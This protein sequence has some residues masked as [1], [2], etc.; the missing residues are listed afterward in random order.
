MMHV[1]VPHRKVRESKKRMCRNRS[2]AIVRSLHFNGEKVGAMFVMLWNDG[3]SC[4]GCG[5]LRHN[6]FG[7]DG[8]SA[9]PHTASAFQRDFLVNKPDIS[10]PSI[11]LFST[12]TTTSPPNSKTQ[13]SDLPCYHVRSLRTS[14]PDTAPGPLVTHSSLLCE[15]QARQQICNHGRRLFVRGLGL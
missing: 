15:Y 4:E 14:S 3:Q 11:L 8:V 12:T 2:C 10:R 9:M 13:H 5:C 6:S 1:Y 7:C